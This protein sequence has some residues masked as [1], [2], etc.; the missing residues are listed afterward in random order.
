VPDGDS[1]LRVAFVPGVTPGKWQRIW[2]ERHPRHRLELLMVEESEQRSVLDDRRVDMAFVRR[3]VVE[4]GLHL[5]P[6]YEEQ[7]VVVVGREHVAAEFD[8]I[9]LADLADDHRHEV[10]PDLPARDAIAAVAAG[11]GI[12]VLPLSVARLHH[13][14]DAVAVPLTDVAS[15]QV[16][17]AWLI[18][19]DDERTQE[20]VGVVR[21]RTLNSSRGSGPSQSRGD[22]RAPKHRRRR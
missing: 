14:K 6:L 15:T 12:V 2:D 21:G 1:S 22:G 16:G 7:P 4:D 5:V 11:T 20:F 10:G 9:T 18:A 3:P 8:E 13:R 19:H 17:L